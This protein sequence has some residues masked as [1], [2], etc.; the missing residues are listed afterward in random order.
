[1]TGTN[2]LYV[3]FRSV[4]LEA[5]PPV[6]PCALNKR[7]NRLPLSAKPVFFCLIKQRRSV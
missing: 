5:L 6:Y 3:P 7:F 4:L 1:M 2:M